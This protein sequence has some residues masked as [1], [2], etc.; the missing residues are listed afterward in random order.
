M[1]LSEQRE[2]EIWKTEI[3]DPRWQS[4]RHELLAEINYLRDSL[5]DMEVVRQNTYQ[6]LL[7]TELKWQSEIDKLETEVARLRTVLERLVG[8]VSEADHWL[9]H[10]E[11][12]DQAREA[13][14]G[15]D[16]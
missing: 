9:R 2:K 1:A 4:I 16:V 7:K 8:E 11:V 12:F 15:E 14:G 5:L 13:L 10:T 3:D 6:E